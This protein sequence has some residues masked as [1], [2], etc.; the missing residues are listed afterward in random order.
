MLWFLG[1]A[2]AG[3]YRA[4]NEWCGQGICW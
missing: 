3:A 1:K 2:A 4:R